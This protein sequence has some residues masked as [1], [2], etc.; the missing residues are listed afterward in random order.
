MRLVFMASAATL[1]G[2]AALAQSLL[3]QGQ[4]TSGTVVVSPAPPVVAAPPSVVPPPAASPPAPPP[5]G[6]MQTSLPPP[7][8]SGTGDV[9]AGSVGGLNAGELQGVS[10]VVG[11]TPINS[12]STSPSAPPPQDVAPAPT[13]DWVPGKTARIGVLDKVDGST[14][15]LIIPVGGQAA[16]GDLTVSVQACVMRPPGQLPD[17][18][19]FI[20]LQSNA[21]QSGGKIYNGWMVHSAPGATDA[22]DAGE[23]FRIITCS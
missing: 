14:S 11:T 16:V 17:S 6:L 22:G 10:S 12:S 1:I 9:G 21:T 5:P 7:V 15:T 4:P 19:A 20:T 3:G 18:A 23:A 13:N 2:C 8:A